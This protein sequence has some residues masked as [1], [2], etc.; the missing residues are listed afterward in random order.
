MTFRLHFKYGFFQTI[1]LCSNVEKMAQKDPDLFSHPVV[2]HGRLAST[3]EPLAW[4]LDQ[5]AALLSA[6]RPV[7][8]VRV[9]Q[10]R[11]PYRHPQ[12]ER[13]THTEGLAAE[14]LFQP[15]YWNELVKEGRW[16]YF[17]YKYMQVDT[18]LSLHSHS[19]LRIN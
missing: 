14:R 19:G 4:S 13:F 18:V 2:I 12:W 1:K 9:G 15:D 3:W 11:P 10:L 5:W 17:D 16:A 7:I 6:A 8:S